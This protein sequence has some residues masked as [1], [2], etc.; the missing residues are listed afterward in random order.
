MEAIHQ[1]M[2]CGQIGDSGL[3]P[4]FYEGKRNPS[5]GLSLILPCP[6]PQ[7]SWVGI[8]DPYVEHEILQIH[9]PPPHT[10]L[11]PIQS[12]WE[13]PLSQGMLEKTKAPN[14]G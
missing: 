13:P 12:S 11:N 10:Y 2:P 3:L 5:A 14:P 4:G 7:Y 9:P 8:C 6:P 1:P